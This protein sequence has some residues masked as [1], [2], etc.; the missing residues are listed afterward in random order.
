MNVKDYKEGMVAGAKPF[1]EKFREIQNANI[2]ALQQ[3]CCENSNSIG[4]LIDVA[5]EHEYLIN[6][7]WKKECELSSFAEKAIF[8]GLFK[9]C[10][11]T[12]EG[13]KHPEDNQKLFFNNLCN[14][15]QIDPFQIKEIDISK[16]KNNQDVSFQNLLYVSIC[17]YFYIV[18]ENFKFE[19][20]FHDKVFQYF[21]VSPN[22]KNEI[23][24]L[25]EWTNNHLSLEN[26]LDYQEAQ[27]Q[28]IEVPQISIGC[29]SLDDLED[30]TINELLFIKTDDEQIFSNKIINF[31]ANIKVDGRCIFRNCYINYGLND[32][33]ISIDKQGEVIFENCTFAYNNRSK[34]YFISSNGAIT[35][36]NSL[37]SNCWS[38]C[39][40]TKVVIENSNINYNN[41]FKF[42]EISNKCN[43]LFY[44][45]IYITDSFI[46]GELIEFT[47]KK[48]PYNLFAIFSTIVSCKNSIFSK[49]IHPALNWTSVTDSKFDKCNN[50]FTGGNNE[51]KKSIQNSEF[52]E[53]EAIISLRSN[54][55][56]NKIE[57]CKFIKCYNCLI[58]IEY[59][60]LC[61]NNCEFRNLEQNKVTSYI[62]ITPPQ[63]SY[64]S[65]NKTI[66][67]DCT[68]SEFS[69]LIHV[70]GK[71]TEK[72]NCQLS[73]NDSM[74]GKMI[75]KSSN[76]IIDMYCICVS[77]HVS[78]LSLKKL[79]IKDN[80]T[81]IKDLL[82]RV[83]QKNNDSII[84]DLE[85]IL[86]EY[87]PKFGITH[88]FHN[89]FLGNK[90]AIKK[91][92]SLKT[93]IPALDERT[94]IGF[95]DLSLSGNINDH[96]VF[97]TEQCYYHWCGTIWTYYYNHPEASSDNVI[98]Y[99][100]N[101]ERLF[102]LGISN[103][104]QTDFNE[105]ITKIEALLSK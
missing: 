30:F 72:D 56:D 24:E 25:I 70:K 99:N 13:R 9:F 104:K 47:K 81:G 52:T 92:E 85:T 78:K 71:M 75:R 66:F 19:K 36:K 74:F 69:Y 97:T 38:L 90:K 87:F 4:E 53:C 68:F 20:K 51:E 86:K 65:I 26:I 34:D 103:I 32:S 50:I 42:E 15:F 48:D 17:N 96:L 41:L 79:N 100:D 3:L 39:H 102:S 22:D 16:L 45:Q 28:T 77:K 82:Q 29:S 101:K 6:Y 105:C 57:N 67:D 94:I 83:Q 44:S 21:R 59:S 54:S 95:V 62:L 23:H 89:D 35:F 64:L 49:C 91:L 76:P 61:I 40:V 33:I 88:F 27:V 63:N 31:N 80:N 84:N 14:T 5:E 7:D 37:L 18:Y 73:I 11:K 10:I 60:S 8:L 58:K 43:N 2:A 12:I 55:N 46:S 98:V 93:L 1:E